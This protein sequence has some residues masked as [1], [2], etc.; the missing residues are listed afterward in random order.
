MNFVNESLA[1]IFSPVLV[2]ALD[3]FL[4]DY[5]YQDNLTMNTI[6]LNGIN[7]LELNVDYINSKHL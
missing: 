3:H 5:I 6:S 1:S 2:K 4:G 7:N